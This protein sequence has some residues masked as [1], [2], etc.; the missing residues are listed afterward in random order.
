MANG[1][2]IFDMLLTAQGSVSYRYLN[3]S[4]RNLV[5]VSRIFM[6]E[7]GFSGG[8]AIKPAIILDGVLKGS[9]SSEHP[10]GSAVRV[11]DMMAFPEQ[12]MARLRRALAVAKSASTGSPCGE[13]DLGL[14]KEAG[15]DNAAF[16][17]RVMAE[18]AR[19]TST[20]Q[21]LNGAFV[22]VATKRV[23]KKPAKERLAI[24]PKAIID[25]TKDFYTLWE[26][27]LPTEDDIKNLLK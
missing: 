14:V 16:N 2:S 9:T 11:N 19:L 7:P 13:F 10:L 6:R 27:E 3:E 5:A 12:S 20:D 21:P 22:I 25:P 23:M 18:A 17:V 15:E 4:G 24:D 26:V 8:K 1:N